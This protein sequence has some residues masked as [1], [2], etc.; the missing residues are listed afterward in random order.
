MHQ[1]QDPSINLSLR[2]EAGRTDVVSIPGKVFLMGEYAALEG[3]PVLLTTVSPRFSL[4][5]SNESLAFHP[6]SPAGK[7]RSSFAGAF[8]DPYFGR[9]GFGASTAQFALLSYTQGMRDPVAVWEKYRALTAADGN[10]SGADLIAQW[11]GG[12]VVWDRRKKSIRKL[13]IP[14]HFRFLLFSASHLEGRKTK[15]HEHLKS[16]APADLSKLEYPLLSAIEAFETGSLHEFALAMHTYAEVLSKMGL[17]HP[18]ACADRKALVR[19]PGVISVKGCGA[20]LSDAV[21]VL[22]SRDADSRAVIRAAEDRG[23]R[24]VTDRLGQEKGIG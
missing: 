1:S 5:P 21:L 11:S 15:T 4:T 23:L 16:L 8:S 19:V 14:S 9:G 20:R 24:F 13:E 17:E 12:T 2:P 18:D 7:L 3:A 22:L 10:P 6:E